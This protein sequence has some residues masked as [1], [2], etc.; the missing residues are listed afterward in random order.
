LPACATA[1]PE[2]R[3]KVIAS[4]RIVRIRYL[5]SGGQSEACPRVLSS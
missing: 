3:T 5:L 4:A 2:P 1:V